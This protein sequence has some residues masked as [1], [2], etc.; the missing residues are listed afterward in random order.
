MALGKELGWKRLRGD[1]RAKQMTLDKIRKVQT[2]PHEL[3]KTQSE[4]ERD[5]AQA[6]RAGANISRDAM[7]GLAQSSLG[8]GWSGQKAETARQMSKHGAATYAAGLAD[9]KAGSDQIARQYVREAEDGIRRA[10]MLAR[11]SRQRAGRTLAD[12]GKFG[13]GVAMSFAKPK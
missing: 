13:A 12:V 3:G 1:K 11:D 10:Q 9:A 5:A 7:T 4:I 6:A 8:S 2:T